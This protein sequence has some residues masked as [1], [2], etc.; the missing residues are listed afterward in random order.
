MKYLL[1]TNVCVV[2]LRGKK[3]LVQA[4]LTAH[5]PADLAVCSV[6]VGELCVGAA[7]SHN[8]AA[9]QVK[10]DNFLAPF[11]SLPFDD[12]AA[13]RYAEIRTHLE[14]LGTPISDLDMVIA[15]IALANNLILVT[16]NTAEFSP[17]RG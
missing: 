17:S 13:R 5:P 12:T 1:D 3:P 15:A 10:V 4:R 8:P 2:A 9:E 14:A 11:R 6:V 16:H 7:K